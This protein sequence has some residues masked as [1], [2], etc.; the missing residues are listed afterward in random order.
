MKCATHHN[1][2]HCREAFFED[3]QRE[4]NETIAKLRKALEFY[5]DEKAWWP[6]KVHGTIVR[7][8]IQSN[9]PWKTASDALT[10]FGNS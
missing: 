7:M 6:V 5:A 8:T 2:C 1:A 4:R 10:S 9:E 3:Q